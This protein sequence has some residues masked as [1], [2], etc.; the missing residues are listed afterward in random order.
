MAINLDH[1]TEQI[2][3]TDTAANADLT[4]V[5][6][7]TGSHKFNNG[8][9]QVFLASSNTTPVNNYV[10]VY[11]ASGNPQIRAEGASASIDLEFLSK[12]TGNFRFFTQGTSYA[13]QF[14]ITNVTSAINYI[15]VVGAAINN[16]PY[17]SA[18]GSDTNIN[19]AYTAKGTGNHDFYTNG[20]SFV[21][22]FTVAHTASAVN[23][24]QVT[25]SVTGGL[26]AISAQGS[27][28]NVSLL[29]KSKGTAN[30]VIQNESATFFQNLSGASQFRAASTASAVN[31][32]SAT[33]SIASSSPVLSAVGSD[34]NIDLVFT[35]K[36]T[37]NV[38]FGTYT[39][40]ILTPTG[41]VEIKDSG[42]T[43]RRLLVG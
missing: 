19:F 21:K 41:Y 37:G 28:S 1:V 31:Y 22:Q 10:A 4:Y 9:G 40:T 8:N 30:T 14:R 42:G 38:R 26:P 43:V 23:Y 34:T 29:L 24:V 35:P 32:L 13:E 36:G 33:G 18:Q 39:G 17:F 7:G 6:K 20:L 16:S 3:V 27:D 5:T 25:G 11:G 15:N 12:S 2:T